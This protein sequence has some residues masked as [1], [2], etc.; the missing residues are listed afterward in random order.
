MPAHRKL[1]KH[2]HEPGDLHELTFSCYRRRPLLTNDPWRSY[3]SESLNYANERFNF[4]LVA[5]VFMPEHVHL[6]MLPLDV[7]AAIDRYLAA[8]KRPVSAAVKRDLQ[9]AQSPLL[10]SLTIRERP[11][12][13]VFRFWQ[14]GPGYDRNLRTA[15]AIL[16][17]IDYIH[18]NPVRRGLCS[19]SADWKWSSA[20]WFDG[21]ASEI[22]PG[23]P[24]L[25]ML[26]TDFGWRVST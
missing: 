6:L 15:T 9:S 5:F 21:P 26:P 16:K 24:K 19:R 11:G 10:S 22:E 3:L 25:A 12:K 8:V 13:D 18:E 1:V 7:D 4:H 23:L 20:R 17:S 14:E 2:F